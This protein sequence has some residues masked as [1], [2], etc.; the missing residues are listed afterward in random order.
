MK[1]T[2]R[3]NFNSVAKKQKVQED[4]DDVWGDDPEFE[5]IDKCIIMAS[6]ICS[7]VRY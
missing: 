6:Q 4:I 1:R 2:E 7:Q 3:F 5:E